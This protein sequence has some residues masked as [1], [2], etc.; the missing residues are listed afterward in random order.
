[1]PQSSAGGSVTADP[2]AQFDE[3]WLL[4]FEFQAPDG[5]LP[6]VLCMVAREFR[7]DRTIRLWQDELSD[8]PAS[9]FSVGP[10]SLVV[11]Y[12]SS[13]EWG[14][15]LSLNWPLP[16]RVLDLFCEFRNLT[17][18]LPVPCGNG[19]L[20]ALAYFD[21]PAIKSAEKDAGRA[22]AI[23]GGPFTDGERATLLEYCE[24]DV[25][26]LDRL[27]TAMLPHIDRPRALLRGRYMV[28]AAR[29]EHVGAPIDVETLD[30]LRD[31][32]TAVQSQLIDRINPEYNVYV[33]A[34]VAINPDSVLGAAILSTAAD[35][36]VDPYTLRDAVDDEWRT[37]KVAVDEQA[38]A[39]KLA[40]METGLTAGRI[41]QW[42]D[43]GR[44][45]ST[46]PGLDTKAREVA[47][48]YPELGLGAG[49]ED[50]AG[51]DATD[52][53]GRL[54][55]LLREEIPKA[56]PK[57]DLGILDRAARRVSEAGEDLPVRKY[58]FSAQRW[59]EYLIREGIP[60]PRLESGALDLS[61]DAFRQMARQYPQVAPMRELRYSLSQLRLNRLA[62]GPDGRN[63]CLLSAFRSRTGRNQPSNAKFIF[64]PSTW[65]RSLI[66]PE[67]GRAV[68]YVDWSQQEFGIVAALSGDRT[69]L[70]AYASGDPY[71]AF[72]K[73]AGAVPIDATK[74]SHPRER[75]QFKVCALAVQYGMGEKSLAESLGEPEVKGREL[76]QL[77]RQT[78]PEFWKWSQGAV[79]RAMLKG[80]L[81]T[82]FGWTIR[83]GAN[84][85]PRSLANFPAQA[86][87]AEMLR[88]ACCL[89]TERGIRVCC[90]V[91]DALLVEGPADRIDEVV[92]DTQAAM[93]EASRV[94]LDGFEL[95]TDAEVVR[96]PE[97]YV[98]GRGEKM[99]AT[100]MEILDEVD[101]TVNPWADGWDE[102]ASDPLTVV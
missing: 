67:P 81:H 31:N 37:A 96:Y 19:L 90:P 52:Y 28:A 39:L 54:W 49:Y 14:C 53:A 20:G 76:L 3:V 34:G 48:R 77:H 71:L 94:V 61:D 83:V 4:D 79:D 42:E 40:R 99:W 57:H 101:P 92:A 29:M 102:T 6:N 88:L 86:N 46:W 56:P 32:W 78:Y 98:D 65:L 70:R 74:E 1:M 18:G 21:L 60:W 97:R 26:A 50:G 5:H 64:G 10:R 12:Y 93:A 45:S 73:Q 75:G 33:P 25:I 38:E 100:V 44:D 95:R 13:A 59:G 2:L 17:N 8:L 87:G 47:G 82:V 84:V 36:E 30:R 63:R 55:G 62:V 41:T 22:L 16:V 69:M 15:F 72:A 91:H 89:A 11:A 68:A 35:Y 23:R 7:T 85:N 9:P 58:S 43:S 51:F 80:S 66:Q 27:L 24:S